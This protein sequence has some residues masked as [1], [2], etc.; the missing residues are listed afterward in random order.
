MTKKCSHCSRKVVS[1][2]HK[3]C[4]ACREIGRKYREAHREERN[5]ASR[6]WRAANKERVSQ[7]NREYFKANKARLNEYKKRQWQQNPELRERVKQYKHEWYMS[8]REQL[9][10][11][12]RKYHEKN[13]EKILTYLREYHHSRYYNDPEERQRQY[14]KNQTRRA[15]IK[16][17]DGTFTFKELNELFEEQEGFCFYCGAL[18]YSSF[19]KEVHI[20]HKIP[21]SRGG[22]NNIENIALS[23]AAC[24][25]TKGAKTHEEFLAWRNKNG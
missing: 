15:Q 21:I 25:L 24:N 2:K 4:E 10:E 23:C 6:E 20:E 17:S 16:S 8:H 7:L 3:T 12:H 18:L 19:D 1:E 5:K 13:R 22:S 14:I 11:K 9:S